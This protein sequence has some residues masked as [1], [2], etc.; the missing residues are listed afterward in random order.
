LSTVPDES[1]TSVML[2]NSSAV[3]LLALAMRSQYVVAVV[4]GTAMK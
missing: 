3:Q 1:A 2:W 4:Y